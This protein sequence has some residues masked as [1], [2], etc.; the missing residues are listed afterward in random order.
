M[1][2]NYDLMSLL[3]NNGAVCRTA[4]A[5]LGLLITVRI[6]IG[7]YNFIIE[8]TL[9]YTVFFLK[10]LISGWI[11]FYTGYLKKKNLLETLTA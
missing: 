7:L 1:E 2:E 4:L 9:P 10:L 8:V 11:E 6:L 5:T 3:I